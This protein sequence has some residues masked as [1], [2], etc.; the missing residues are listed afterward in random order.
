MQTLKK[1]R[2]SFR[3]VD[4]VPQLV[5]IIGGN[6]Q[7]SRCRKS[8]E[9]TTCKSSCPPD[10]HGFLKYCFTPLLNDHFKLSYN[11][12]K[13]EKEFFLSVQYFCNLYG[14]PLPVNKDLFPLNLVAMHRELSE[15]LHK[16][17]RDLELLIVQT[18]NK[19]YALATVKIFDTNMSLYYVPVKPLY[20][21]F[22]EAGNKATANLLLSAFAY[23]YQCVGVAWF[24]NAPSYLCGTYDCL[25]EWYWSS[26][27][28]DDVADAI[29]EMKEMIRKSPPLLQMIRNKE[30]LAEFHKRLNEFI[31]RN[32]WE[33]EM[34][35]IASILLKLYNTYGSRSLNDNIPERLLHPEEDDRIPSDGYL[36]FFWDANGAVYDD[37]IEHVNTSFQE[38]G[39]I[40]EPLSVQAF[41]SPQNI[42]TH[43]MDYET[44][45]FSALDK[46]CG[47][48]NEIK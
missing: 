21:L 20:D 17:N 19:K 43:E 15:S 7:T 11:K 29:V 4:T 30:H 16:I 12:G 1:H 9:N 36:S 22:K 47:I 45:L 39:I 5:P 35:E 34:F 37:L 38:Y 24:H 40:D 13:I 41:D 32:K 27:E 26:E 8:P 23:L 18:D 25:Q 28:P 44:R 48:L 14:L 2:P 31:P 3:R 6:G 10:R 42:E 46:L 33:E